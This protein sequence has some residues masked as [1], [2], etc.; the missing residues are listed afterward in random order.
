M[1]LLAVCIAALFTFAAPAWA[2]GGAGGLAPSGMTCYMPYS[3]SRDHVV[4]GCEIPGYRMNYAAAQAFGILMVLLPDGV[5]SVRNTPLYFG[6]ATLPFKGRSLNAL[7]AA[8]F[9]RLRARRPGTRILEHL[10]HR[11]P[12]RAAGK[13]SASCVGLALAYPRHVAY[14]PYETYFICRS[15]SQRYALVLVLG[16]ESRARM[17]AAMPDFLKWMD[18]PQAVRDVTVRQA[19]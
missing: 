9:R 15:A 18:V 14:L 10:S 1:R 3:A 6:V 12:I 19:R 13:D 8:D 7:L 16:A 5:A 4:T 2:Q 17:K 11:L